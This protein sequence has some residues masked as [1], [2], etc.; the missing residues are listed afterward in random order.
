MLL[1]LAGEAE[2]DDVPALADVAARG[3][4][5]RVR[6]RR[7]LRLGDPASAVQ[8]LTLLA[9]SLPDEVDALDELEVLYRAAGD[10]DAAAMVLGQRLERTSD[11]DAR[12]VDFAWMKDNIQ[13]ETDE[14]WF[15]E[16][17]CRRWFTAR[18]DTTTDRFL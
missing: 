3:A 11:P 13:G 17:G 10:W 2:I 18:R 6:A 1:A 4:L 7:A 9:A 15:H 12:N 16:A 8:S 5:L 14:R